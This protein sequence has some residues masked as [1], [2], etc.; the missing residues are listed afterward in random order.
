MEHL[1]S[2]ALLLLSE[3]CYHNYF[4]DF[5]FLDVPCFKATLSKGLGLGIIA[6]SILVKVPQ[7]LKIFSNKSGQ[8]IN[9]LSVLLDLFVITSTVAYGFVKGFPFSSWGEGSFLAI[10]TGAI[11]F[12]VLLYSGS[13]A[14]AYAFLLLYCVAC[15]TLM[16]GL[17]PV[18]IL[19]SMQAFNVPILLVGKLTQAYTN[20]S[21]GSTG[22]LSAITCFMLFMGSVA[23]IFTSIQETGDN[24]MILTYCVS[25]FANSIIVAQLLWYWNAKQ[26]TKSQ[27]AKLKK[28]KH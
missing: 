9:I 13:K 26:P 23:R 8:G 5:N 27:K 25:S 21:N 22:Q 18:D 14:K 24:M 11:A 7:I 16:S 1:K 15:Y 17:T 19:W 4:E 10:Q 2:A 6:G 28:K 3:K 12:L 20:Y